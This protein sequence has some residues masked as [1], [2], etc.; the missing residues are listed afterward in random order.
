MMRR[1]VRLIVFIAVLLASSAFADEPLRKLRIAVAVQAADRAAGV[2]AQETVSAALSQD[3]GFEVFERHAVDLLLREGSLNALVQD[4]SRR[5]KLGRLLALDRFVHLRGKEGTWIVE[6]VDAQ[7]GK[8]LGSAQ[9]AHATELPA[10]AARLLREE[11][12]GAVHTTRVAVVEAG[13]TAQDATARAALRSIGASLRET[14]RRAGLEVLD[15][16]VTPRVAAEQS[17]AGQGF[18][19]AEGPLRSLLGAQLLIRAGLVAEG[20]RWSIELTLLETAKG[21]VVASRRFPPP[22]KELP[23]EVIAWLF[24]K[25][26]LEQPAAEVSDTGVEVE[27]L[28]SF[29]AGIA[30]FERGQFFEAAEKFLDAYTSND[31]FAEAMLWEARCYDAVGLPELGAAMRHY[32]RTA[33]VGVGFSG[34]AR[35][36]PQQALTFLGVDGPASAEA[37]SV[38]ARV[39]MLGID[40]LLAQPEL[41]LLLT[42]ELARFRDEYD[43]LVGTGNADGTRWETAPRFA[44]ERALHGVLTGPAADGQWTVTWSILRP[45][46][47]QVIT[48][49]TVSFSEPKAEA[50]LTLPKGAEVFQRLLKKEAPA[51][52]EV[53]KAVAQPLPPV[54]ELEERLKRA[55]LTRAANL[56][57]LQL[58]LADPANALV[59]GR[60]LQKPGDAKSGLSAFLNHALR[61][62]LIAVLPPESLL[63]SWLMLVQTQSFTDQVPFGRAV[64]P[65]PIEPRRAFAE[66]S[67]AHSGDLPGALAEYFLLRDT[68]D[69]MAPAAAAAKLAALK[70]RLAKLKT[71]PQ[72]ANLYSLEQNTNILFDLA[73]LAAGRATPSELPKTF[74]PM[75]LMLSVEPG[76]SP[77]LTPDYAWHAR[78]WSLFEFTPEERVSEAR[79]GLAIAGQPSRH[80]KVED[81]LLTQEPPSVFLASYCAMALGEVES[82]TGEPFLHPFD[83]AK[84]KAAYRALVDYARRGL[85]YWMRRST[86]SQQMDELEESVRR[87]VMFTSATFFAETLPDAEQLAL[88]DE[89][90][91]EMAAADARVGRKAWNVLNPMFTPWRQFSRDFARKFNAHRAVSTSMAYF[92][93]DLALRELEEN[94]RALSD[95]ESFRR[96]W[97]IVRSYQLG[98]SVSPDIIAGCVAQHAEEV[99]R[100]FPGPDFSERELGQLLDYGTM[101]VDG[102]QY[103]EAQRAYRKIVEAPVSDLNRIGEADALRASAA[104]SLGLLLRQ[105]GRTSEAVQ[106]V[107]S[108]LAF[109]REKSFPLIL[110]YRADTAY[111][112]TI[113]YEENKTSLRA[114]ALRLLS[115]LRGEPAN[116]KLPEGVGA[117]EIPTPNVDNA[118]LRVYYRLPPPAARATAGKPLPVLVLVQ[119]FNMQVLDD[120]RHGSEWARFA[121]EAGIVLVAPEFFAHKWVVFSTPASMAGYGFPQAWSGPALLTALAELGKKAPIRQSGLL[122]HGYGEGASFCTRFARWKPELVR[123]VSGHSTSSFPWLEEMNRLQSLTK[124]TRVP[125]LVTCGEQDGPGSV[126]GN[127]LAVA[128]QFTTMARGAGVPVLYRSWP[129]VYH[130][131]THQMEELSRAFLLAH[132]QGNTFPAGFVGDRRTWQFFPA[133]SAGAAA[134]PALQR[135][136]LPTRSTALLWGKEA[137]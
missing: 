22:G 129:G 108:A 106:S 14:L 51:E 78:D 2:L 29:Y 131:P 73:S 1:Q 120:L 112:G 96:W 115:D 41:R 39:S 83:A 25:L 45:L 134:I 74:L 95:P 110:R 102:A 87:L 126:T 57:L 12:V 49:E 18:A 67:A 44:S 58:V 42:D 123:A 109:T 133:A 93:K 24:E 84:E 37:Q 66:F 137:K 104:Y 68:C 13:S 61:D 23:R 48:R 91:A 28:E 90:I 113:T 50:P 121:D 54:A 88:R 53:A 55:G 20:A 65:R 116:M 107:R 21:R 92:D 46:D 56:P 5:S 16:E 101:L 127:R 117:I 97:N 64:S 8:L 19:Q 60:V 72:W 47:G 35:F 100:L 15:R 76:G 26:N 31:K 98:D 10:V 34:N 9:E 6:V 89:L 75:F 27:A 94:G 3:A 132:A 86:T 128:E 125:F 124:L 111:G 11:T 79:A 135:E 99:Q 7:S 38:A 77:K 119:G 118:R 52:A 130:V 105:A 43:Q 82:P 33:L 62:H 136:E 17:I 80:F 59:A 122:F 69:E 40:A 36:A 70:A 114:H 4:E 30:L 32:Q 81:R 103:A 71:Q 63:R 85:I